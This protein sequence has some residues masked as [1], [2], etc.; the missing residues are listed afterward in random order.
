MGG[1]TDVLVIGGANLDI[2]AKTSGPHIAATSNPAMVSVKPGG[3]ARNIAH[4]LARLGVA[5]KLLAAVGNDAAGTTL[6]MA[7]EKA[8]VDCALMLEVPAATGTYIAILDEAGE[9]VT[10]AN[11]MAIVSAITSE[12]IETH[13]VEIAHCRFVVADCNLSLEALLHLARLAGGKLVIE[14]VS[15]PK[16]TRLLALLQ[17]SPVFL[18]TPNLDQIEALTGTRNP[19]AAIRTLQELGLRHAVVHAGPSGAFVSHVNDVIAV[20]AKPAAIVDVTGAGDAATAGL[21]AGLLQN[22][23][24]AKAAA[25]GQEIAA[26]VIASQFSTLE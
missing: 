26:R 19:Q 11:D 8:G 25:L 2:K 4:N 5:T 14:P 15:V 17:Q 12:V 9:L 10:A 16:A 21:I 20:P 7:T 13:K 3:V 18:A 24:L 6:R 1:M 23:P 22:L